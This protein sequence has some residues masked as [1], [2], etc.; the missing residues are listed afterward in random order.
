MRGRREVHRRVLSFTDE[1][2]RGEWR[3]GWVVGGSAGDAR[4]AVRWLPI[5]ALSTEW[6]DFGRLTFADTA[7]HEF[8]LGAG[9]DIGVGRPVGRSIA[10]VETGLAAVTVARQAV[11]A[12]E[13]PIAD[14]GHEAVGRR[15]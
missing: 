6:I 5:F 14:G 10:A 7:A 2:R 13:G 15:D 11:E 12:D 3:P 4:G 8:E 9:E 1:A